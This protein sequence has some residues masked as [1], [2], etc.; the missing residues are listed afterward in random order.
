M[1][2]D[3]EE[4]PVGAG[5]S[6]DSVT[7]L[8]AE[9]EMIIRLHIAEC[10]RD[11]G[12]TVLE[13]ANGAE[14]RAIFE[15]GADVRL[16]FSDIY[17]PNPGDGVVLAQW[18]SQNFPKTRLLLTSAREIALREARQQCPDVMGGILKPYRQEAVLA[19]VA[20]VLA[21]CAEK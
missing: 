11:N 17:M 7:I 21:R 8:V 13:A 20:D 10:L 16:L 14:A 6:T 15:S 19:E 4:S 1:Q 3:R 9:D 2:P 5:A 18:V 12:Y